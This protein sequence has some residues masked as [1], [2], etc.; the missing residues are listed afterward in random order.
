MQQYLV[1]M[2]MKKRN[3][4]YSLDELVEIIADPEKDPNVGMVV[5][6]IIYAIKDMQDQLDR[7]YDEY[8][9]YS[10]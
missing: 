9:G 4:H 3:P 10:P 6:S 8:R 5:D 2:A 1:T 7:F